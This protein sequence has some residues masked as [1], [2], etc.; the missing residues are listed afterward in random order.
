MKYKFWDKYGLSAEIRARGVSFKS[1]PEYPNQILFGVIID[2]QPIRPRFF[3]RNLTDAEMVSVI[4]N[5]INHGN[6]DERYP[7]ASE[8]G[9]ITIYKNE[10]FIYDGLKGDWIINDFENFNDKDDEKNIQPV[11]TIPS[12]DLLGILEDYILWKNT[13]YQAYKINLKRRLSEK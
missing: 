2:H 4:K 11:M 12:D 7:M 1:K 5:I 9:H 6:V 13:E 8:I 3:D 10:A